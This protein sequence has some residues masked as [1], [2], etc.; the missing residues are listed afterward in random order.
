MSSNVEPKALLVRHTA[1][2]RDDRVARSL[3]A[4]GFALDQR[5]VA[6]GDPLPELAEEHAVCVVYGG[7][8]MASQA[9]DIDYL[10]EELRWIDRW[11]GAGRPFLGICLGAQMLARSQGARVGTHREGLHEIGYVQV[12]P[13]PRGREVLPEPL[14]VY[15][16]H[17]EG[18]EV[19]PG[20]ELLASGRV[21]EN[22]AFR[23]D[24][25]TYGLQFH[26]EVTREMMLEWMDEAG[27]MLSWP[28]AQAREAQLSGNARHHEPLG[29]WLERFLDR[30]LDGR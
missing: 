6:K 24:G 12:H 11:V 28:G 13:T 15:H 21:F 20:A 4:R 10:A 2:E 3:T 9:E 8:Q 27:H 26:P 17:S 18:F 1:N 14:H 5:F 23:L 16:W 29:A 7:P 22:Q 19:P 30:L 25:R